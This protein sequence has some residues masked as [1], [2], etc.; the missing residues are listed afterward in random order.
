M[1]HKSVLL[2]ECI[3]NLNI[4]DNGIYVDATLGYAGHSSE[5]LKRIPNGFLYGFDQ[6]DF[7]IMK[8]EE[9]LAGIS[10][11]YQI[12]KSNFVNLREELSK[13]NVSGVDGVLF[14]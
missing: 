4:K 9:K 8:S 3:N 10:N 12:I 11:N 1:Y 5:I 2:N 7:A 6:D 13:Y 14:D